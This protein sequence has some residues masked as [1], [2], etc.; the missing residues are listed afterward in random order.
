MW[1]GTFLLSIVTQIHKSYL[2]SWPRKS[3]T[4]FAADQ[5][6]QTSVKW[7]AQTWHKKPRSYKG[8]GVYSTNPMQTCDNED[9]ACKSGK[10]EEYR[11]LPS[12]SLGTTQSL[13]NLNTIPG[14]VKETLNWLQVFTFYPNAVSIQFISKSYMGWDCVWRLKFYL[15]Q[16]YFKISTGNHEGLRSWMPQTK[17]AGFYRG[18]REIFL[19]SMPLNADQLDIPDSEEKNQE[20]K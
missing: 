9:T 2:R 19:P 5:I 8:Q 17:W 3:L 1:I 12:L 20:I 11:L 18:W 4:E 13:Q 15:L 10:E 14:Q 16:G 7:E 6:C